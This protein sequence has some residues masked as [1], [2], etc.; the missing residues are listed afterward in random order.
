[1]VLTRLSILGE[2][3]DYFRGDDLANRQ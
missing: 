1:M 2:V 3:F